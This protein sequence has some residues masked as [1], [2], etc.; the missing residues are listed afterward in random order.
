MDVLPTHVS[1]DLIH[2]LYPRN[3]ERIVDPLGL[4]MQM[5]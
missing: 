3:Q 5:L 4:E 2:A 1:M